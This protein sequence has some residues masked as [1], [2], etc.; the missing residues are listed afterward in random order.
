[1]SSQKPI[2]NHPIYLMSGRLQ[3]EMQTLKNS[4]E[5]S[6]ERIITICKNRGQIRALCLMFQN[7]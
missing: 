7:V 2:G 6:Q 1:M 3:Y 4:D 5:F